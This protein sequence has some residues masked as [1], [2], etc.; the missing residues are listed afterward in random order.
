MTTRYTLTLTSI[1]LISA[2]ASGCGD[3]VIAAGSDTGSETATTDPS[4]S[5][6]DGSE[7][8][9]GDGD[10]AT[11]DGDGD[12]TTGDGDGDGDP[13]TGDGD[14][15]G[16]PQPNCIDAQFV[17]GDA[18][19]PGYDD[20][21]IIIGS[22]CQG[23]NHQDIQNVER[24]VFL[25]DS[26]TVG[27]PPTPTQDF[28]RV[29]LAEELSFMF[30]LDA[31]NL[32]WQTADP[33]NGTSIIKEDGDFASCAEWGAR[34]DD[35]LRGG[36][37]IPGCF[38]GDDF[39][40]RT[41]VITT[42]GGNDIASIAKDSIEGVTE[43]ALWEDVEGMI[44]LQRQA[45]EWLLEPGR[46]PN[47]VYVVYANVYEFTDATADLL[48][49]PAAG[50]AGFDQNP[51]DPAQLIEMMTYI[52][53]EYAKLAAETGTDMVFMFE[54]LCGHGFRADDPT[55]ECYRGPGNDTWFD[56]TCIHPT[57]DGHHAL[58]NMFLDVI[59]E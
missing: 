56:L 15:D 9:D 10:P 36:N 48:S 50:L 14:G 30:G 58:A 57:P 41:L 29:L 39:N 4:D 26:V 17:S 33:I 28:Y 13:T 55:S 5:E 22:H 54:G 27:T 44:N 21:G 45:V 18:P 6:T 3:E 12:P 2:L 7:P 34:T 49:C 42:M 59:D 43:D 20:T 25:G 19:G 11:G 52:N 46:F 47:G 23:T 37:Q 24:V 31:P 35:F 40:K 53:G 32:L 38:A 51:D 16:D 8:G 1:C